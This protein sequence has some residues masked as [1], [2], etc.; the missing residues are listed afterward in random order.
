MGQRAQIQQGEKDEKKM[1]SSDRGLALAMSMAAHTVSSSH[2]E[3]RS[4][5][6]GPQRDC[7]RRPGAGMRDSQDRHNVEVGLGAADWYLSGGS[8][9]D[10]A[11]SGGDDGGSRKTDD[12]DLFFDDFDSEQ[13]VAHVGAVLVGREVGVYEHAQGRKALGEGTIR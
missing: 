4:A 10:G 7:L 3:D 6:S 5:T 9:H 11:F 12:V 8:V 2:D 1:Q 13:Q